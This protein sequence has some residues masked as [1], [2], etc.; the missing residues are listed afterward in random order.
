MEAVGLGEAGLAAAGRSKHA[1]LKNGLLDRPISRRL[2]GAHPLSGVSLQRNGTMAFLVSCE[3]GSNEVP[4]WLADCLS[5]PSS[6]APANEDGLVNVG[7]DYDLGALDAAKVFAKHLR[8]P[9]VAAKYSPQI[10]DVNRS[11]RRPGVFSPVTRHLPKPVRDR[12]VREIHEPYR[13][14]VESTVARLMRK[15]DLVIHLS[16][17]SFATFESTQVTPEGEDRALSARRTD[18][19]LLYDPA[20]EYELALCLD[21]YDD[22]YYSL[23]M[24]R[25]R[26][27]YPRR[28]ISESLIRSL[29]QIYTPD[30]YLGIE[31]QLNRAW[32][33]RDVP[34]RKKVL[35]GIA[36]SLLR[37]C[38]LTKQEQEAA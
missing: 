29:R 4:P 37:L 22:L 13:R 10:V 27:N 30:C 9:L 24:L 11:I 1:F 17:H 5:S 32:C 19:G 12:I 8:C 33:V 15:D 21:W 3:H 28:G 23:P 31:L 34:V 16:V 25:V 36:K 6:T 26:R 38:D 2:Q 20:R 14:E 35:S 18:L 7:E